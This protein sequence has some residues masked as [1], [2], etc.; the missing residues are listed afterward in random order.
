MSI[1]AKDAAGLFEDA[2]GRMDDQDKRLQKIEAGMT[3]EVVTGIVQG[4]M[5]VLQ[6]ALQ[7]DNTRLM[8]KLTEDVEADRDL[9]Q[10]VRELIDVL[11]TPVTRTSTINLPSGPVTLI[12][13]EG[14]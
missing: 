1:E 3:P 10:A 8:K 4:A 5:A 6:S 7:A 9:V 2:H 12:T 11:K 14:R 13:K